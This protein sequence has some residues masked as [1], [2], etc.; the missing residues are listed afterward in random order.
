M[1]VRVKSAAVRCRELPRAE[2]RDERHAHGEHEVA[3]EH[4]E[5]SA[6]K[7]G[8]RIHLTVE[9]DLARRC[10]AD[11][12][13]DFLDE[14]VEERLRAG[15]ERVGLRRLCAP[16]KERL[17]HEQ[18]D[19]SADEQRRDGADELQH[20]RPAPA[21][22]PVP[23]FGE[24]GRRKPIH[25]VARKHREPEIHDRQQHHGP[26]DEQQAEQVEKRSRPCGE[27]FVREEK[28][29]ERRRDFHARPCAR[30]AM[31]CKRGRAFPP[32]LA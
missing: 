14:R 24:A 1:G 5:E 13:A 23:D 19:A 8:G 12:R 10:R 25:P 11:E 30:A 15:C 26:R 28:R 29:R 16:R 20:Q 18:R 7:T 22:R 21:N 17:H 27:R 32:R 4:A 3:P 6:A 2:P 31:R 9:P